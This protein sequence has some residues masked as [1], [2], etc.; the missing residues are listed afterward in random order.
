MAKTAITH[1][2]RNAETK[3]TWRQRTTQDVPDT[4]LPHVAEAIMVFERGDEHDERGACN[5][6]RRGEG[7]SKECVTISD[8]PWACSNCI[9]DRCSEACEPGCRRPSVAK[10]DERVEEDEDEDDGDDEGN[11][12]FW[13]KTDEIADRHFVL[14]LVKQLRQRAGYGEEESPVERARQI[15]RAALRVSQ[16]TRVFSEEMQRSDGS[17]VVPSVVNRMLS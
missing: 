12:D 6:C 9:Y 3:R 2:L 8:V 15:E 7:T 1:H 10:G 16:L 4:A 11:V 5:R 17:P 13:G 14:S